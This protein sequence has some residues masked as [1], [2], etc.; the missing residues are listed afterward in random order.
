MTVVGFVA[1]EEAVWIVNSSHQQAVLRGC[2]TM[3]DPDSTVVV[4]D[5]DIH[6]HWSQDMIHSSVHEALAALVPELP[7]KN[8]AA[9][10]SLRPEAP[11]AVGPEE[12]A[13]SVEE[14]RS[15]A[16]SAS[17]CRAKHDRRWRTVS[18]S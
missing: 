11:V 7:Y 15:L 5:C 1:T 14:S 4:D 10:C 9:T 18:P 2:R 6:C 13:L 8:P 16:R 3:K 17:T 12:V